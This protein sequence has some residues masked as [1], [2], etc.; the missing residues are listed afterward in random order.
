MKATLQY[1][2][3]FEEAMRLTG[4]S[5]RQA[6][7][8]AGFNENQLNRFMLGKTDIRLGTWI[9]LCE[10]GFGLPCQTVLKMGK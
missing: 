1:R 7:L 3:G 5:A 2:K 4:T 6:S 8:N 10:D 9:K